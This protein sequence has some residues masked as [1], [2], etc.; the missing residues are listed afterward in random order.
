MVRSSNYDP[1]FAAA[2]QLYRNRD[3]NNAFKSYMELAKEGHTEAQRFVGWMYFCGEGVP[4]DP[5]EALKW[6]SGPANKGD[7]EAQFAIGRTYLAM[8]QYEKAQSWFVRAGQAGFPPGLYRAGWM[9]MHGKGGAV[10]IGAAL[11]LF[12]AAYKQGHLRSGRDRA[13]LLIRGANGFLSRFT[14]VAKFVV[15]AI[16]IVREAVRDPRSQRLMF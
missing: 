4:I 1:R 8:K 10:N 16:A 5:S 6:L 3:Y 7:L 9:H 14:G 11:D 12:D 15:V 2:A 13:I